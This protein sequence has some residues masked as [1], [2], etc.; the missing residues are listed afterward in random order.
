MLVKNLRLLVEKHPQPY[1]IGWLKRGGEHKVLDVC[2]IQF[3]IGKSYNDSVRC[4]VVDMD[5]CHLLLSKPWQFDK[6]VNYDG[7]QN[8]YKFRWGNKTLSYYLCLTHPTL[9][10]WT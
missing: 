7:R 3:S 10:L 9:P 5:A 4:D 1:K 8:T 6:I 2:E